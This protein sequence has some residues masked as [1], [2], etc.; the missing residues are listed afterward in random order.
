MVF[1]FASFLL[2]FSFEFEDPML[3][4]R[5]S[6]NLSIQFLESGSKFKF[7]LFL[8]LHSLLVFPAQIQDCYLV[9]FYCLSQFKADILLGC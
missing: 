6:H 8:I 4:I 9:I 3:N 5:K 1:L 2:E 7:D